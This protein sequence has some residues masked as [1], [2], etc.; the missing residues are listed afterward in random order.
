MSRGVGTGSC[1]ARRSTGSQVS[2][3]RQ[4][5][6]R[7]QH[8]IGNSAKLREGCLDFG[9]ELVNL[10]RDRLLMSTAGFRILAHRAAKLFVL[11]HGILEY[12]DRASESAHL[13]PPVTVRDSDVIV[14][15][16]D[17]LYKARDSTERPCGNSPD[18]HHANSRQNNCSDRNETEKPS[19]QVNVTL[20]IG[21][22]SFRTGG[23]YVVELLQVPV[24]RLSDAA[25]GIVVAPF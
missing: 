11:S 6:C 12:D 20:E 13:V 5:R 19:G 24:E 2:C 7:R 22:H 17:S 18:H 15:G 16:G 3:A 8:L 10:D 9:A 14:A 23:I 21:I 25:I 4:L 1:C